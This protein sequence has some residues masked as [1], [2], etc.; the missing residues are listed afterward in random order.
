MRFTPW[1][2]GSGVVRRPAGLLRTQRFYSWWIALM[3]GVRA[4]SGAEPATSLRLITLDPG[5]FHAALF[6]KEML[7]GFA[8]RVHIYAPLG[9]DLTMHLNRLAQFNS[10]AENPT[11]WQVEVHAGPNALERLLAERPGDVVVL[12]GNNRGKI[13]RIDALVRQGLHVLADK[14]WIIE[15]EE[16]SQL[17]AALEAAGQRGVAAYDAMTQRFE[18]TCRLPREL[19]RDPEVFG[20][21]LTGS[22]DEP[23]VR[24][25]SVHYLLKEV[26]GV[27]SLR[28]AWFFDVRQLGEGL[29]DV[30]THL[31][32]LV[33]WTLLPDQAID[34]RRDVAVLQGSH[35]PTLLTPAQFQRVT[36]ERA[37]PGFL[38]GSVQAGSLECFVNNRV[39]YCLR[40]VFVQLDVRWEFEA[41]PGSRDSEYAAFR[42]TRARIEVRQGKEENY[43]PEVYIIPN[44][45][46]EQVVVQNALARRLDLLRESIPGLALQ[47]QPGRFRIVIPDHHRVSHEAHFALLTRQFLDYVRH[48]KAIPAW[49]KPNMLAK[50]F[51]TTQGVKL[52]REAGSSSQPVVLPTPAGVVPR[53]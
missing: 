23:A 8:E 22:L 51:I 17:E 53:P 4:V 43:V 47:A 40:G 38:Q 20:T 45:E 33:A 49:E 7:P 2:V 11:R 25:E 1:I 24:M 26:A 27:P 37:F 35:W 36:G 44:R 32:D 3:V 31:V 5:H 10:R 13:G 6:H 28:P 9:P 29:A 39:T 41:A 18:I 48:P 52:A 21:C 14:P 15:P 12:S 42:G 46:E 50:Y 30:G 34:Y 16:L 19:L